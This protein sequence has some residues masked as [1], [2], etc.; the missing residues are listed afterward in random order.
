M[1]RHV[2]MGTALAL[3]A[4]AAVT[5]AAQSARTTAPSGSTIT[6]QGCL[7]KPGNTGSLAGTPLG[8]PATPATAGQ[9]A[10]LDE[11]PPGFILAGAR[12]VDATIGTAGRRDEPGGDPAVAG[13]EPNPKTFALIGDESSL[14]AYRGQQVELVGTLEP[15]VGSA[16]DRGAPGTRA[17]DDGR[18]RGATERKPDEGFETG[19]RQLRVHSVKVLSE[20]CSGPV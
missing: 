14:A 10:N 11:P 13:A 8:T 9:L 20:H 3:T 1:Y 5:P 19:V 16:D 6:V 15:P 7:Q 18:H 12:E 2:S 17:N 4:A